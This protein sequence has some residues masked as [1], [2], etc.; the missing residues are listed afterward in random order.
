[1]RDRTWYGWTELQRARHWS[2]TV[3]DAESAGRRIGPGQ[4]FRV[5]YEDLVLQPQRTVESLCGFLRVDVHPSMLKFHEDAERFVSEDIEP[6]GHHG[7]LRRPPRSSDVY[8]WQRES[9]LLR[10]LLFESIAGRTMDQLG[11]IRKFPGLSRHVGKFAT[12]LYYPVGGAVA[13]LHRLYQW[14][15]PRL[16]SNWR[17]NEFLRTVKQTLTR[18]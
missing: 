7:K 1:L 15:P 12:A 5:S 4:Y 2:R 8:R 3:R 16:Q 17:R 13:A 6:G 18:C 14:M 10:V 11:M 9:S